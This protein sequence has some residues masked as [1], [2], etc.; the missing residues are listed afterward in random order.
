MEECNHRN[1]TQLDSLRVLQWNVQGL[2]NKRPEILQAIVEEDLDLVLLQETLVP[3]HFEK[4]RKNEKG[5]YRK[6][7]T[8]R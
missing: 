4:L 3:A 2:R 6:K 1:Y 8:R 5:S 7:M